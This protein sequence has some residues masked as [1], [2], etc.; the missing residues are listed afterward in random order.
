[1]AVEPRP[2]TAATTAATAVPAAGGA[3]NQE[4]PE[5]HAAAAT[6]QA[7]FRGHLVRTHASCNN[8][9]A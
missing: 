5:E 4:F 1:M 7:H 6:I 8:C 3:G 2:M 9:S